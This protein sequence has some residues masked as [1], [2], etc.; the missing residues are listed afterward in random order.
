L[1]ASGIGVSVRALFGRSRG[2]WRSPLLVPLAV[3]LVSL[4]AALSTALKE[5]DGRL[6]YAL[7]DAY[8]HMAVAKNLA[9]HGIWGCTPFHWSSSSSSLLWTFGLGVAY[10]AFGVHDWTPLVLNVAFAIGTLLVA[11]VSLLRFGAPAVLRASARRSHLRDVSVTTAASAVCAVIA[12]LSCAMDM[13]IGPTKLAIV[14][15]ADFHYGMGRVYK[16]FRENHPGCTKEVE[17]FR[18]YED[19]IRWLSS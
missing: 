13:L 16:V 15:S 10:R 4:A 12:Q 2:L 18:A 19:A 11:H 8:I 6:I 7:D 9:S 5:T 17:V 14:A 1:R 3:F